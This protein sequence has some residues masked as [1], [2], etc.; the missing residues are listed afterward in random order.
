MK[1][2][3]I[4]SHVTD[5]R[6]V[7]Q[8]LVR[9]YGRDSLDFKGSADAW[10]AIRFRRRKLFLKADVVLTPMLAGASDG[11]LEQMVTHMHHVFQAVPAENTDVQQKLLL[12][13]RGFRMA[14]GVHC[15]RGLRGF[16]DFIFNVAQS[17]DG[18]IFWDGNQVLD[19]NGKLV[20]HFDGSGRAKDLPVYANSDELDQHVVRSEE[21]EARKSASEAYLK[22]LKVPLNTNLPPINDVAHSHMRKQEAV[23]DRALALCLVALKGEGL[24]QAIVERI[25]A[26]FEMASLLSPAEAAFI[27]DPTPEQQA[28]INHAWRY[29]GLWVMLWALGRIPELV[30]PSS[31]CDVKAAV[32]MVHAAGNRPNFHAQT[33]LRPAAEILDEADRIYRM[34]WAI[35]DARLRQ[36]PAPADLE[37]GVVY[38]RHFALNWLRGYLELEWDAVRT[39][40]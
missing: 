11:K 23:A 24:E 18:L 7:S 10:E 9:A 31:I 6:Q 15:D 40:T 38:E 12:R 35:V 26:D 34:H 39:D 5:I 33:R 17:V 14:I 3:T 20:L 13:I 32:G 27:A 29:E 16:E 4:F 37:P 30:Y 21:A 2:C 1:A 22:D 19:A 8:H 36:E 25:K 28:R